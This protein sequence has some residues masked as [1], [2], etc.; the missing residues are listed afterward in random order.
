M[1]HI[2]VQLRHLPNQLIHIAHPATQGK[3]HHDIV[4]VYACQMFPHGL[5]RA[6]N[7]L[8]LRDD[9][10]QLPAKVIGQGMAGSKPE[11][12]YFART[13]NGLGDFFQ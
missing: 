11:N 10:Q 3:N 12:P 5:A 7:Q 4:S 1:Q 13:Q 9:L 2:R 8:S 6:G